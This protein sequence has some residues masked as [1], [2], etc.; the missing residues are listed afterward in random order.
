MHTTDCIHLTNTST[1]I[2]YDP[3]SCAYP[4]LPFQ[5]HDAGCRYQGETSRLYCQTHDHPAVILSLRSWLSYITR[6][7][8]P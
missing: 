4:I 5:I 8:N 1:L 3:P 7:V 6:R 2:G